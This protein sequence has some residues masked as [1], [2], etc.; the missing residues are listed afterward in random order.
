MSQS[1][2]QT[3]QTQIPL[4]ERIK[5]L[6]TFPF[7]DPQP[8]LE[9]PA[10][11]IVLEPSFGF[12]YVDKS[13]FDLRWNEELTFLSQLVSFSRARVSSLSS[14]ELSHPYSCFNFFAAQIRQ[15]KRIRNSLIHSFVQI[16]D[17]YF[18]YK[19]VFLNIYIFILFL[20]F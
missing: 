18:G 13:V 4:E 15:I 5:A 2:Q 16:F 12:K 14:V 9:A 6:E 20:S 3:Q 8:N 10:L 17:G 19:I 1:S 11:A 7:T